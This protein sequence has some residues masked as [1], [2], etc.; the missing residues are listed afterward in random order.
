MRYRKKQNSKHTKAH[1]S[2]RHQILTQ[3]Y[4]IGVIHKMTA[5]GIDEVDQDIRMSHRQNYRRLSLKY[6]N[7]TIK[8]VFAVKEDRE[9]N[10]NVGFESQDYIIKYFN[11]F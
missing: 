9:G 7:I 10:T 6:P 5:M 1:I 4:T 11:Y 2:S 3:N 8:F